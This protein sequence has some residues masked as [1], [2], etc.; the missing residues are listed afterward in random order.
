M[1]V[2][3]SV[4]FLKNYTQYMLVSINLEHGGQ[5]IEKKKKK[6]QS[7]SKTYLSQ[8]KRFLS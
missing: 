8:G 5:K 6:A 4:A 7:S 1:E 3:E 2:S